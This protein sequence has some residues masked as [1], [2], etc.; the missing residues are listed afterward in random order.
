[1]KTIIAAAALALFTTAALAGEPID[2]LNKEAFEKIANIEAE[3]P[4]EYR[5]KRK[6]IL[7]WLSKAKAEAYSDCE[8]RC[9]GLGVDN[10]DDGIGIGNGFR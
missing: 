1:M 8:G 9:R 6:G 10:P 7:G 5:A 2:L 3:T 4:A